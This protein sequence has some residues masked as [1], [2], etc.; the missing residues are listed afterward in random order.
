MPN[1]PRDYR[2]GIHEGV[3][4]YN[5]DNCT[6][7]VR[8][9]PVLAAK[10]GTV[11]RADIDYRPMTRADLQAY[12]A[13]PNTETALDQFRGRQVWVQH[14]DG[15]VTRYCH[16]DGLAPGL[17]NGARVAAG[18]VIAFVGETGTPESISNPGSEIHLH[19]EVRL[20]TT[21]LGAG[22]P[23]AEVRSLYATL[24]SP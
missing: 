24:F 10:A 4:F 6:A 8:G 22:L 18:Q 3:D 19:F 21:F 11:I 2:R 13:N 17:A 1:A 20:G 23:P 15:A 12:L 16:L 14:E 9:T 7:V 5:V